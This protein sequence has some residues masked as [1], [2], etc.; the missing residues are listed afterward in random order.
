MSL[1]GARV[2]MLEFGM[3]KQTVLFLPRNLTDRQKAL[4]MSYAEDERDVEGT[5][6]GVTATT[7]G[8]RTLSD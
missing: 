5:V 7:T 8:T 6:N 3:E 4:L 1:R 2:S